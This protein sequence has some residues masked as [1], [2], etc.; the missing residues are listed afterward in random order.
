[1]D[2][3]IEELVKKERDARDKL[4]FCGMLALALILTCFFLWLMPWF[5]GMTIAHEGAWGI[6]IPGLFLG[7]AAVWYGFYWFRVQ[8]RVEYEYTFTNG[9]LDID[10]IY[11]KRRRKRLLTL[12]I[13]TCTLCAPVYD[14]QFREDYLRVSVATKT[15]YAAGGVDSRQVCFA[16]FGRGQDSGRLIFT[17]SDKLLEAMKRYNVKAVFL[18]GEE[19]EV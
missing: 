10:G 19:R 1:M 3:F 2:I 5:A 8:S 6:G 14:K 15:Y 9:E 11:G 7:I 13:K 17:P 16:D 4:V 18:R 12:R